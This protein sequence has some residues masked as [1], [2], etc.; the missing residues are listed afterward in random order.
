[1]KSSDL[2]RW[3][4]P[5]FSRGFSFLI[6]VQVLMGVLFL[7]IC[8]AVAAMDPPPATEPRM[9]WM[10]TLGPTLEGGFLSIIS[11]DDGGSVSAGCQGPSTGG[12]SLYLVK[13]DTNG[14]VMWEVTDPVHSTEKCSLIETSKKEYLVAGS[15]NTSSGNGV[16]LQKYDP[17]GKKVWTQE[18]KKGENYFGNAIS[19]TRNGGYVI[20]GSVFRNNNPQLTF[21]D[22]YIIKTDAEGSELWTGFFNGEKNDF[23]SFI[24]QTEDGGYIIAGTTESYGPPGGQ[25]PFLLKMNEFGNKEWFTAFESGQGK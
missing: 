7:C 17:S 11:A 16:F 8:P 2:L 20:A 5:F 14:N 19:T 22:G 13:T 6:C 9:A 12:T 25:H 10:K 15:S 23:I 4:Y 3:N 24:N 21:W 18:Y 1:M